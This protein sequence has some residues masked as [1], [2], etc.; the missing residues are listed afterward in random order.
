[1]YTKRHVYVWS[2]HVGAATCAVTPSTVA[3]SCCDF[4][5]Q[6]IFEISDGFL[7]AG[8]GTVVADRSVV[9]VELEPGEEPDA[10]PQPVS[11]VALSAAVAAMVRSLRR[12]EG[13][14]R[15]TP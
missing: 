15:P 13:V 7:P 8:S 3:I 2:V 9:V 11:R 5:A 4:G 1:E 12:P 10:G 14:R 6:T